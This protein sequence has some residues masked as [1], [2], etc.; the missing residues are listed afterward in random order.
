MSSNSLLLQEN[1]ALLLCKLKTGKAEGRA[2]GATNHRVPQTIQ[3]RQRQPETYPTPT[4]TRSKQ[5]LDSRD[6]S[7]L[8]VTRASLLYMAD[9]EDEKRN[10]TTFQLRDDEQKC[11][12][13]R[14][15]SPTQFDSYINTPLQDTKIAKKKP[16]YLQKLCG[17]S[18]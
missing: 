4:R 13:G 3:T 11:F 14:Y 16:L 18:Y 10:L 2:A 5:M 17:L 8:T 12:S 7:F 6:F 9:F 1:G 15:S